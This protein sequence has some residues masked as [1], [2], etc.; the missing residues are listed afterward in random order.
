[1]DVNLLVGLNVQAVVALVRLIAPLDVA[2]AVI[3][4]VMAVVKINVVIIVNKIVLL[5]AQVEV[6]CGN[7]CK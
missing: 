4:D 6:E 7:N 5:Y 3:Q 1:M 2:L